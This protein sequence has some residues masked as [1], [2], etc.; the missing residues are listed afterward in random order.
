MRLAIGSA[1]FALLRPR[2][3]NP[4]GMDD[5]RDVPEDRQQDVDPEMKTQANCEKNAHGWQQD[6][7]NDADDVQDS[8]PGW[9]MLFVWIPTQ[10][11]RLAFPKLLRLAKELCLHMFRWPD[12]LM[13]RV[14]H[15]YDV[16]VL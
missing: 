3:D 5:A 10:S 16:S 2:G 6:R 1:Q 15:R 12:M 13:L 7:Q 14:K 9:R 4:D 8:S 11:K